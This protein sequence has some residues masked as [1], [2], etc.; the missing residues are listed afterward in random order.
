VETVGKLDQH[1]ADI[2]DHREEH[3][4][5]ALR[6][7]LLFACRPLSPIFAITGPGDLAKLGRAVHQAHNPDAELLLQI[8]Q[9]HWRVLDHVMQQAGGKRF[10]VEMHPG[11]D[12]GH[13]ERMDDVRLTRFAGHPI[14]GLVCNDK[15][16]RHHVRVG[17]V[18]ILGNHGVEPLQ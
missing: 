2:I 15:C 8:V 7:L 10:P 17:D 16:P 4:A 9:R 3:L 13:L 6:L 1:D 18:R 11:Q 14:V 12:D 5:Q